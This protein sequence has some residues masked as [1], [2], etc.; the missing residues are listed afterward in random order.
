MIFFFLCFKGLIAFIVCQ[1]PFALFFS[2]ILFPLNVY[3]YEIGVQIDQFT[4]DGK[5]D[6][7]SLTIHFNLPSKENVIR[8]QRARTT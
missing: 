4:G 8:C 2:M 3:S 5:G 6:V 1:E 7:G